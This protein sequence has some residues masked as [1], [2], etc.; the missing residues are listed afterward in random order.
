MNKDASIVKLVESYLRDAT[1]AAK[2]PKDFRIISRTRD[3]F[4]RMLARKKLY[5][6]KLKLTYDVKNSLLPLLSTLGGYNAYVPEPEQSS[7]S[8]S[9]PLEFSETLDI[10]S[11]SK[12][13]KSS[14][15]SVAP[16]KK[17]KGKAPK[18]GSP[19]TSQQ[20]AYQLRKKK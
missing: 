20:P 6:D 1:K 8:S 12:K 4:Y 2:G 9:L 7:S 16:D 10:D 3:N 19:S 15:I 17:G 18:L 14:S 5:I 13:P 11:K